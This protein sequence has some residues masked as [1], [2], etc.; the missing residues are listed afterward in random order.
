MSDIQTLPATLSQTLGQTLGQTLPATLPANNNIDIDI[1]IEKD[2]EKN[3]IVPQQVEGP[4][5]TPYQKLVELY[6]TYCPSLPK[7]RIL[8]ETRKKY[9][10]ARW[11]EH[12]DLKFWEDYFKSVE[13]SDFLTGRVDYGRRTPFLA[14]FEWLIR[15]NNF[16]KVIEGKYKNRE[17]KEEKEEDYY[18][19]FPKE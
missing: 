16:A 15:P 9:L 3:N 12:P 10:N 2:I 13:K 6:H 4:P 19:T 11:K 18:I 5:P 17:E 1:D 8:T 14:D 7:V